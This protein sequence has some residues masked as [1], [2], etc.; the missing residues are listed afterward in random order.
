MQEQVGR[1]NELLGASEVLARPVL[2]IGGGKVGRATALALGRRGL[3]VNIVEKNE[4]LRRVIGVQATRVIV[5]DA[6][7]R[8]VLLDAG[9]EEAGSVVLTT[10]DDAVNIYLTVYCRRLKPDLNIVS[11]ITHERNVEAIYRA[12]ADF[13][14]S[15]ASL[16]REFVISLLF[17]REPV[18][19]GEGADFFVVQVPDS[20][21]G[22]T[23]QES[24][25]GAR[26]G[27][28]VIAIEE[29][30]QTRTNPAPSLMLP[31]GGRLVV[32]G[33]AEQ[34]QAFSREFG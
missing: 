4:R 7:D 5:G 22:K 14:L 27:L 28:I 6:A 18:L 30:Q 34:R 15:Y 19:I 32:L 24:Q 33:T 13:V 16:G 20:I 25:I 11:R 12:G 23:L 31:A 10:N 17:G 2:V 9:L 1:L 21:A 29:D 3:P 26:T 8:D